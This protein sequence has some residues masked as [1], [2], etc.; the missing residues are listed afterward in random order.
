MQCKKCGGSGLL[1]DMG[2][3]PE[4]PQEPFT[5][6]MCD[7]CNGKGIEPE[8]QRREQCNCP[9]CGNIFIPPEPKKDPK[10]LKPDEIICPVCGDIATA[11]FADNGFGA[12]AVQIEPF[13]CYCGWS[14][15]QYQI[16]PEGLE[17]AMKKAKE[18]KIRAES[19]F[20]YSSPTTI[21][22]KAYLG[23]EPEKTAIEMIAITLE[24]VGI[25]EEAQNKDENES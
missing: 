2:K 19:F 6:W 21:I 24:D 10:T 17:R 14:E 13:H 8:K 9:V 22:I 3:F 11:E 5:K 23:M 12:Y 1:W 15:Y 25:K 7:R 16:D 18:I 4:E 20:G